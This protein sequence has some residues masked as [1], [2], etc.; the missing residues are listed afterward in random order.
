MVWLY[1]SPIQVWEGGG[2]APFTPWPLDTTAKQ[3]R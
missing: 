1:H 3:G 2:S